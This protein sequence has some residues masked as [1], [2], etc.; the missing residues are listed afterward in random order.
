MSQMGQSRRFDVLS[1]T[2][3]LPQIADISG[4]GRYFAFVPIADMGI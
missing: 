4:P 3:A 1:V 2:S